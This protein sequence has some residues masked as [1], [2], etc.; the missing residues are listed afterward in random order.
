MVDPPPERGSRAPT[1]QMVL[2]EILKVTEMRK[3][4]VE[5]AL[6]AV[7]QIVSPFYERLIPC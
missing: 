5:A 7:K 4:A 3:G 6:L 1:N 2:F